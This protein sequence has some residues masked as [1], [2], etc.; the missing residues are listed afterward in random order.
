MHAGGFGGF[1]HHA[2]HSFIVRIF[3]TIFTP[4]A[5]TILPTSGRSSAGYYAVPPY[6][7]GNVITYVTPERVVF[8]PQAPVALTCKHSVETVTVPAEA[9]GTREITITRC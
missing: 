1:G 5:R 4:G 7:S 2:S 6:A 3:P 9:G 8:V